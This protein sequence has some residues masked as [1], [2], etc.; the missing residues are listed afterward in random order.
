VSLRRARPLLGTLVDVGVVDAADAQA[1]DAGFAAIAE[2]QAR[3]SR[4][5]PGS[6]ISRFHALRCGQSLALHPLTRQV[7][8]AACGLQAESHGLFDISL[9]TAPAGWALQDGRLHKRSDAV[10]LDLG[11]IG[12]G[13]AVDIAVQAM[14]AAGCRAGWVNAGGDLRVFGDIEMP[15]QL[16]CEATGGVRAFG[17]LHEGA[18]AT[19]AFGAG[20]RAQLAGPVRAPQVSVAA[21]L[22]LWA[23][24]LTK[25]VAASGDPAHPLLVRHGARAFV[26]APAVVSARDGVAA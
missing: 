1:I 23:D 4:F 5:E 14:Q 2:A 24:A 25:V 11:G 6:D 9:G 12:K 13:H 10:R 16:R 26:H 8:A 18:L 21:P 22:C 20:H 7:L 19:S 17:H 15:L 3:L